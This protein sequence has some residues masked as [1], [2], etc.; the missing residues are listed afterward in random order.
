M[1]PGLRKYLLAL[2][3]NSKKRKYQCKVKTDLLVSRVHRV[4]F[5]IRNW[6]AFLDKSEMKPAEVREVLVSSSFL[7]YLEHEKSNCLPQETVF[8]KGIVF[9]SSLPETEQVFHH[10][11]AFT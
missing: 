3:Y 6:L 8:F 4:R 2:N 11:G 1:K 9:L 5:A 10:Q 7:N